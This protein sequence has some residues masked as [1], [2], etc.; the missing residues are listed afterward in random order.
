MLART[1][2]CPSPPWMRPTIKWATANIRW[3]IPPVFIRLPAKMKNGIA[4][5]GNDVVDAYIRCASMI[6]RSMPPI[7][8]MV[9]TAVRARLMAMGTPITICPTRP[10]KTATTIMRSHQRDGVRPKARRAGNSFISFG[11]PR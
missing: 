4:R 3:V 5:S 8:Y 2:T 11:I 1:L 9:A 10:P 6:I 7:Q